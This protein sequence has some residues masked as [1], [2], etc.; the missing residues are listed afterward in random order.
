[1]AKHKLAALALWLGTIV[2]T[3]SI[4]TA[5]QVRISAFNV[6][7]FGRSKMKDHRTVDHLVEILSRYDV[8]L[9]QEIKDVTNEAVYQLLDKLNQHDPNR[10]YE[11]VM[12][13][14][15]GRTSQKENY[16]FFYRPDKIEPIESYTYADKDDVFEREPFVVRFQWEGTRFSLVGIHTKPRD[17]TQEIFALKDVHTEVSERWEDDGVFIIGDFNADCSYYNPERNGFQFF[18]DPMGILITDEFD[19]TVSDTDCAYDRILVSGEIYGKIDSSWVYYFDDAMRLPRSAALRVSDHYPVV[20]TLDSDREMKLPPQ[21]SIFLPKTPTR[22][23]HS[24]KAP[25]SCG[26]KPYRTPKNYCFA[27][28]SGIKTRVANSCCG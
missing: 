21:H 22:N 28:K 16:G 24:I 9:V 8:V 17:A 25:N 15:L 13:P 18:D 26:I 14:R 10:S 7:N 6:K 4:A 20:F 3:A 12:S 11:L 19:T 2:S 23:P 5:E 1:M 27:T